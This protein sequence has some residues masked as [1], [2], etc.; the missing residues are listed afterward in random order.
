MVFICYVCIFRPNCNVDI[1]YMIGNCGE[2][3]RVQ[4]EISLGEILSS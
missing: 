4:G 3:S 1:A 2:K